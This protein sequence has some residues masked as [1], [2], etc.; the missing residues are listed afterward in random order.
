MTARANL[1]YN[2]LRMRAIRNSLPRL[3]TP[4]LL[5]R[6]QGPQILFSDEEFL[7]LQRQLPYV[8]ALSLPTPDPLQEHHSQHRHQRNSLL[9][10][11]HRI[12]PNPIPAQA[13]THSGGGAGTL[14]SSPL[15]KQGPTAG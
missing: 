12:S 15:R 4:T 8:R 9:P 6:S 13:G 10:K 7:Y 11:P 1:G 14:N 5:I 2:A 3:Q